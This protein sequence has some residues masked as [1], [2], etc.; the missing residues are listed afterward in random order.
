MWLLLSFLH[1]KYC[2]A[3]C[4]EGNLLVGLEHTQLY[5][6]LTWYWVV[7]NCRLLW[8][9][10][11]NWFQ[12]C[13]LGQAKF[14]PFL[15]CWCCHSV[16]CKWCFWT[17]MWCSIMHLLSDPSPVCDKGCKMLLHGGVFPRASLRKQAEQTSS[18]QFPPVLS[19]T[20]NLFHRSLERIVELI[21]MLWLGISCP[22]PFNLC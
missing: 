1:S 19:R 12:F 4:L 8:A 13:T 7:L 15:V 2:S 6:S 18:W 20:N 10:K 9:T 16:L 22:K 5:F 14:E 21:V 3:T 17:K 11:N